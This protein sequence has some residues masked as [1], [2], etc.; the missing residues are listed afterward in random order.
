MQTTN[1]HRNPTYA[2]TD[3]AGI[4]APTATQNHRAQAPRPNASVVKTWNMRPL[5]FKPLR[6]F[7]PRIRQVGLGNYE[8]VMPPDSFTYLVGLKDV[9]NFFTKDLKFIWLSL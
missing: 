7:S 9:N 3:E 8:R 6:N 1:R 5:I 4:A 2:K